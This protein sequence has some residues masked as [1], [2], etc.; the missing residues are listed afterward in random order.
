M[1]SHPTHPREASDKRLWWYLAVAAV[2]D[3]VRWRWHGGETGRPTNRFFRRREQTGAGEVVVVGRVLSHGKRHG[4]VLAAMKLTDV[5]SLLID[6]ST[7][8]HGVAS[9]AS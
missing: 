6:T 1:P 3:Y 5:N 4:P 8:G 2:P 9:C 7:T